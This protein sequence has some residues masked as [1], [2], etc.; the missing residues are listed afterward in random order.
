M[1]MDPKKQ[2]PRKDFCLTMKIWPSTAKHQASFALPN[3]SSSQEIEGFKASL[4]ETANDRT[5]KLGK[6]QASFD[7]TLHTI[8]KDVQQHFM[9]AEQEHFHIKE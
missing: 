2:R 8:R 3:L 4:K 6:L 1:I 7:A 5:D 9:Y